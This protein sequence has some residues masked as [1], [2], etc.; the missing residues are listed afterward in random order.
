MKMIRVILFSVAMMLLLACLPA[1]ADAAKMEQINV[2]LE[3]TELYFDNGVYIQNGRTLVE[4]RAIFEELGFDVSYDAKTKGVK[5][6]KKGLV[7]E[8][9]VGSKQAFVNGQPQT[10]D[11]AAQII[12][13]RTFVPLRF[14]SESAGIQVKWVQNPAREIYLLDPTVPKRPFEL[15]FGNK[16]AQFSLPTI[17]END[18][19]S[20]ARVVTESGMTAYAVD[21]YYRD[22]T[23]I[24]DDVWSLAVFK[25]QQRDWDDFWSYGMMQKIGTSNDGWVYALNM[26]GEDPYMFGRYPVGS[27]REYMRIHYHLKHAIIATLQ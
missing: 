3:G 11:V 25:V 12:G 10:L 26:P 13:G 4:F 8:L 1:Q 22:T 23:Y 9:K 27:E 17:L 24:Q 5:G 16:K 15:A 18:L 2:Y 21:F 6:V 7:I 20:S 14:V 19:R